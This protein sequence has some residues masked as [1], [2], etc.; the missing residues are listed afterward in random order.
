MADNS[1]EQG[2]YRANQNVDFSQSKIYS[3]ISNKTGERYIGA[4]TQKLKYRLTGHINSY[5]TFLR[6][7][8]KLIS[9]F[10][11]IITGDYS[12][13]LLEN[14][15]CENNDEL[16][17]RELYWIQRLECVNV[18]G[19]PNMIINKNR[20]NEI[21]LIRGNKQANELLEVMISKRL[22]IR[23]YK[24][25]QKL[26][27]AMILKRQNQIKFELSNLPHFFGGGEYPKY[28]KG[29]KRI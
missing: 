25:E 26:L 18:V 27:D 12:I 3:I 1:K 2:E 23:D 19:S 14:Y 7:G 5:N 29:F 21:R 20:L 17:N 16:K 15:P 28:R 22:I 24:E 10:I 6:T 9:S 4:T 11:V 13:N 8:N